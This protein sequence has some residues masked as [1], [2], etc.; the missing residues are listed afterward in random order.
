MS[1]YNVLDF[2][3]IMKMFKNILYN[4]NINVF[5]TKNAKT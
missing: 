4:Q 2:F 1:D 3:I 5:Y